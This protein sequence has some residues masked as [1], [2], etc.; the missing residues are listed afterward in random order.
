MKQSAGTLLYR[1]GPEGLEVLLVH[2]SGSYNRHAPWGIPKGVP[3]KRDGESLEAT[4]RRETR[5]ETGVEATGPLVPL[6]DM[7]YKK[8]HKQV[9]CFAG[10]APEGAAPRVA[11]WEVDQARFLPIEEARRLIHPDQA[12]FLDRLAEHLRR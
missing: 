3:D 5:E 11:S 10:P 7:I 4:A 12:V 8:S 9:H 1:D 6:G 2:P